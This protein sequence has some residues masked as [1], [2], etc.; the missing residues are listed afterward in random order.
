MG[1]LGLPA[2]VSFPLNC[3]AKCIVFDNLPLVLAGEFSTLFEFLKSDYLVILVV[4]TW[5]EVS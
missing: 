4:A 2:E 1:Y 3:M 5:D